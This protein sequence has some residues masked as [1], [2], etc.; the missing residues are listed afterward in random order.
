VDGDLASLSGVTKMNVTFDY[1][2]MRVGKFKTEKEYVDKKVTD[3]NKKEAGKGDSWHES[4]V[5]DRANRFEPD[6]IK[7]F[8]D[9]CPASI[10][11]FPE[12]KYTL[13]FKTTF[14]EPGYNIHI[15]KKNASINGEVWIVETANQE[16]VVAKVE[17]K[18]CPGRSF[19]GYDYDT[20][21]RI[22]ESYAKAGKSLGKYLKKTLK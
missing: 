4:W 1:S 21:E 14:T 7:L 6:F 17:I 10:G 19:G 11:H 22:S 2:D 5:A 18:N 13:I 9:N 20:G 8:N 16:N 15:S 12:E 3:Y